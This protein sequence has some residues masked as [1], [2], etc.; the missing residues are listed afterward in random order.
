MSRDGEKTGGQDFK[1]GNAGGP[2]R[3]KLTDEEKEIRQLTRV[4]FFKV[5]WSLATTSRGDLEKRAASMDTP[6]LESWMANTFKQG[7]EDGD[8][9]QFHVCLTRIIGPTPV[10]AKIELEDKKSPPSL[11]EYASQLIEQDHPTSND[12]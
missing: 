3:T 11:K 4:E 2:G 7:I 9:S 1:V 10:R 5:F 6:V 12:T 8:L